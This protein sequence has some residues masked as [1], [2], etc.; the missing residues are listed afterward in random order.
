MKIIF[1]PDDSQ[2]GNPYQ[3]NLANFLVKQGIE[4]N[5]AATFRRFST[6]RAAVKYWKPDI[7]HFHWLSDFLLAR[8]RIRTILRSTTFIIELFILKLLGIKIVWTVHNIIDHEGKFASIELFFRKIVARLCDKIIVHSQSAKNTVE[9]AYRMKSDSHVAIILHG[10][11]LNNYKNIIEK[12]EARSQL[13]IAMEDFV[14]L[15]FGQIRPYK[16]VFK[17]IKDFKRLNSSQVKLLIAGKPCNSG[18]IED[19][20]KECNV[21]KN[22]RTIFKFIPNDEVQIYMNASDIVVLPYQNILTSGALILAMSFSKP[23]IAPTIGDIPSILDEK[24]GFLYEPLEKDGLLKAT[25]GA[26]EMSADELVKMG[27]HNFELVRQFQWGSIA[28]RTCEVYRK[29]L[30]NFKGC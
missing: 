15:L 21:N 28:K 1:L 16:G 26:L 22:I 24:G 8:S 18:M 19:I 4:V 7:L 6:L 17:L 9:K 20:Q 14:F 25:R 30:R 23:V 29:C 2:G 13:C 27:K 12:S 11:Y 10:N 5:F 3:R